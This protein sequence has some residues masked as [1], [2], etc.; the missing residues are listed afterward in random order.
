MLTAIAA[1]NHSHAAPTADDAKPAAGL[2]V[3]MLQQAGPCSIQLIFFYSLV[4]VVV[5]VVLQQLH[6]LQIIKL[7]LHVQLAAACNFQTGTSTWSDRAYSCRSFGALNCSQ[8]QLPPN[9][10]FQSCLLP[11]QRLP[12]VP[13]PSHLASSRIDPWRNCCLQ[14]A[15]LLT[16][17]QGGSS[18]SR[19]HRQL[20]VIQGMKQVVWLLWQHFKVSQTSGLNGAQVMGFVPLTP[21][22][23]QCWPGRPFNGLCSPYA[24]FKQVLASYCD[25][26][27]LSTWLPITQNGY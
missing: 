14:T 2:I 6:G 5:L 21:S 8:Q 1:C 24:K 23:N 26:T 17:S 4:V 10:L 12:L 3:L 15:C 7:R 11:G 9:R 20:Q 18:N 19:L 22:S 25:N 16:C 13:C 27:G